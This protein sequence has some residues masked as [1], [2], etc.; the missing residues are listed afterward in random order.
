[1]NID[2][3][4]ISREALL[5][6]KQLY[7]VRTPREM[8]DGLARLEAENA[9]ASAEYDA[10]ML[11]DWRELSIAD[12]D[13]FRTRAELD[14]MDDIREEFRCAMD[15]IR[16]A[17]RKLESIALGEIQRLGGEVEIPDN[18]ALWC[19][20]FDDATC[21]EI[22]HRVASLR[23]TAGGDIAASFADGFEDLHFFRW[24][25]TSDMYSCL[26]LLMDL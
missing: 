16:E 12:P 22:G 9:I 10:I 11:A 7:G 8:A 4:T 19:H 23:V 17:E 13:G 20:V 18:R 2:K 6:F 14:R 1:M 26:D 15:S 25:N 21:D 5:A 3:N 24:C